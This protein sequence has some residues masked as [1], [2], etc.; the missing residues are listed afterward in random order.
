MPGNPLIQQGSLN[1]ILASVVWSDFPAFNVTSPY[2][3]KAGLSLALE[4]ETTL[5]I[6]T[7][8]GAVQSQ[9]PYMMISLT[10]NL[11]KTQG[12]GAAYKLKMEQ[13]SN[14]GFGT[15]RPDSRVLGSYQIFNCAMESVREMSF[16]GGDPGFAVVVKGY[17]NIN[18]S[19]WS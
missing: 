15:V 17:Y 12:L 18:A 4:G 9:E 19:L 6:P 16:A 10:M 2:L 5:L 11:L 8:T 7:M 1:R 14:L 3:G 13:D